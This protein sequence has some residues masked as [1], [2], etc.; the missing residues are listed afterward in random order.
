MSP[1]LFYASSAPVL[2]VSTDQPAKLRRS[3]RPRQ[4]LRSATPEPRPR[5]RTLSTSALQNNTN[6]N[7]AKKLKLDERKAVSWAV[8]SLDDL[9][10]ILFIA[11]QNT[12]VMNEKRDVRDKAR[13]RWLFCHREILEP[14]LPSNSNFFAQL[15]KDIEH[16]SN[17]AVSFVPLHELD[18][19]PKLIKGGYMKDYQ[20]CSTFLSS[21][22]TPD[23]LEGSCKGFHSWCP[24]I[25]MVRNLRTISQNITQKIS[26]NE[27]YI[28][29]R[30]GFSAIFSLPKL[31]YYVGW[32][33]E[34]RSRCV[35]CS[36]TEDIQS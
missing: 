17:E 26:R 3:L 27:L 5:K 6:S 21:S 12:A 35:A 33:S 32:D 22:A 28:G 16:S 15:Q 8:V 31:T 4:S 13:K 29:R 9:E 20:V 25:R 34:R 19:Q 23:F 24:C 1:S 18:E 7:A 30:V 11:T 2:K 10:L 36:N 14:L